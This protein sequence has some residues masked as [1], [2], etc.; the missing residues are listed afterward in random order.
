LNR[1]LRLLPFDGLVY[2][3]GAE[4]VLGITSRLVPLPDER[5]VYGLAAAA[6][7]VA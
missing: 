5:G 2:L 4:T 7:A 1:R 6:A 3:G